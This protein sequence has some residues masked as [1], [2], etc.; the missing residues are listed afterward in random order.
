MA[1]GR[2]DFS[3]ETQIGQL[4]FYKTL[5][6][7]EKKKDYNHSKN[8]A[9]DFRISFQTILRSLINA[10]R[11]EKQPKWKNQQRIL[12]GNSE[13]GQEHVERVPKL[14]SRKMNIKMT[15][16]DHFIFFRL[17]R[18]LKTDNA[19]CCQR[20]TNIGTYT[21]CWW[22]CKLDTTTL[23]NIV[24]KINGEQIL[25]SHQS[26]LGTHHTQFSYPCPKRDKQECSLSLCLY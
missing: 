26:T 8:K 17:G 20:R 10:R 21:H 3:N 19:K 25:Q 23:K 24:S 12:I 6:P 13:N 22:E 5:V 9:T 1:L 11:N 15:L 16:R 7:K 18:I 4:I 2:K 14:I